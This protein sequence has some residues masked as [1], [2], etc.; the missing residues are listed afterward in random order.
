MDYSNRVNAVSES[1]VR[2][3]TAQKLPR[4]RRHVERPD[5]R[6]TLL[7]AAETLIHE[8]GYAAATARGVAE[9]VGM[10]HQ[11]VFY[12]FGS[13]DELLVAV[14][15][16]RAAVHRKRLEAAL[17]SDQPLTAM[18]EAIRDP[19]MV[20]FTLEYMTLAFHSETIRAV[21]ADNA[22]AIRHLE[23][24]AVERHLAQRGIKPRM[25]PSMVS[26]L[27]NAVARLLV[28]EASLGVTLG[29]EEIENL[30]NASFQSFEVEG[31]TTAD[32]DPLVRFFGN[33]D[34]PD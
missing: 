13:Q 8:D 7:N 30:S 17:A 31:D 29:H 25:S 15:N 9:R 5:V 12:Y 1:K 20:R 34:T 3:A 24:E 21:F 2:M 26:I 10:K 19:E 4:S 22:V 14:F 11:V 32:L 23:T 6:E 16:R 18:W 33:T 28:Q 27:S